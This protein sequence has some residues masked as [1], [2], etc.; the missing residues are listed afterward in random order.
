MKLR[1]SKLVA[2]TILGV[3]TSLSVLANDKEELSELQDMSDPLA[4]Y[5]MAGLGYTDRGFN[6]KLGQSYDSGNAEIMAMNVL[7]V[8]GFLGE[9][10]GFS[11]TVEP[12]NSIDYIRFRNFI[13][14]TSNGRG[15]QIDLN[16]DVERENLNLSYS[17]IQALP[18]WGVIQLYPLAGVGVSI[19]NNAIGR[20][21]NDEPIIES[22]YTMEG[23]YTVVGMYTKI[24]VTDEIWLNY[25]P[26][27][28]NTLSGSDYYKDNAYGASNSN[29]LLH[30][31]SVN[32]QFSPRANIRYFANYSDEVNFKDGEHRIEVNYQF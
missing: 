5:S 7:E 16:I 27:Y 1:K 9:S 6:F 15:K 8:K 10:L 22:G 19:Q 24:E 23:F 29:M 11:Q 3:S 17:L 31:I 18:K 21:E 26:M 30:E 12:D 28:I 32:Y 14:N 20:I 2:L 13:V 4:V 25:N